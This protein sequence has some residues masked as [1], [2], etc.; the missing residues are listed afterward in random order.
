[1]LLIKAAYKQIK[2]TKYCIGENLQKDNFL[3]FQF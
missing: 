2:A 3:K 1:M